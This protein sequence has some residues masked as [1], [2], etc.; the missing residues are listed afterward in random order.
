LLAALLILLMVLGVFTNAVWFFGQSHYLDIATLITDFIVYTGVFVAYFLSRTQYHG[1]SALVTTTIISLACFIGVASDPGIDLNVAFL[2]LSSLMA[3]ALLP[4]RQAAILVGVNTI[5][6]FLLPLLVP[7]WSYVQIA[8]G[9]TFLIIATVLIGVIIIMRRWDLAHIEQQAQA[10]I[11]AQQTQLQLAL[12]QERIE[13]L[14]TF[15]TSA[16]HEFRTPLSIVNANAYLMVKTD[17]RARREDLARVIR[18][19]VDYIDRLVEGL[20]TMTSLDRETV[21]KTDPV[22]INV[23]AQ[24]IFTRMQS[25]MADKGLA[26][27]LVLASDL[28]PVCGDPR[29]LC[30][31]VL[32]IV[33]NAMRY[34]LRGGSV[35]I[36]TRAAA[37]TVLL[38][39]IDSGIGIAPADLPRV[40][41]RFYRA[42]SARSTR[43][44]GLGLS[45]AHKIVETHHGQLEVESTPNVGSTFRFVFPVV[46]LISS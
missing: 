38:E 36:I 45:I 35:T 46:E 40:F 10:L 2:S 18:G 32:C 29:Q 28:P 31:A 20:N 3:V 27:T 5:G 12:E 6:T 15:I 1:Q 16:S 44:L 4:M 42:D 33:D 30:E 23:V 17:D 25:Q 43:G 14:S 21:A 9:L 13:I 24:Q 8:S 19:Q 37:G 39:V 22:Q 7:G 11:Q 34:T 41:D 26:F